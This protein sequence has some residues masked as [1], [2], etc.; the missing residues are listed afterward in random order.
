MPPIIINEAL[1]A[2]IN[3]DAFLK[4]SFYLQGRRFE[5]T[6]G[7]LDQYLK[8]LDAASIPREVRMMQDSWKNLVLYQEKLVE[9]SECVS[10]D[11]VKKNLT[12]LAD[13]IY[14]KIIQLEGQ[15]YLLL[16]GG[17]VSPLSGHAVVYQISLDADGD[18]VFSINNSGDGL[19]YHAKKSGEEKEL[20]NPV[21]TYKIPKQQKIEKRVF[22]T[23]L[24]ALLTLQVPSLHKRK[25][26]DSKDLYEQVLPKI[27][28][29]QGTVVLTESESPDYW[30]TAGQL[31]GT[32]AQHS[33]H[34]ML[35]SRHPDLDTY[36]KFI[37]GFKAH[38]LDE[39]VRF[40]KESNILNEKKWH[41]QIE[42]AIRH[43][44]KLLNLKSQKEPFDDLF[45]FD[46]KDTEKT[47]L[48]NYLLEL[49]RVAEQAVSLTSLCMPAT[50]PVDVLYYPSI[51]NHF[52]LQKVTNCTP[53]LFADS[54]GLSQRRPWHG[55]LKEISGGDDLFRAMDNL[56]QHC[57]DLESGTYDM[58]LLEQLE[59]FFLNLPLPELNDLK[60]DRP[61][62]DYYKAITDEQKAF[63]FYQKI[64][65]LQRFYFDASC[66]LFSRAVLLPR[67][68]LIKLSII[69]VTGYLNQHY[70]L[71][72]KFCFYDL[73]E[74]GFMGS[75][76]GPNKVDAV[77]LANNFPQ[78][79]KRL[80]QIK[81]LYKSHP[82]VR[83]LE[84]C[85]LSEESNTAF[86]YYNSL[87][88][89]EPVL[90]EELEKKY[91]AEEEVNKPNSHRAIQEKK[92][93]ALYYF[94][95]HYDELE[96]DLRFKPLIDKFKIQEEIEAVYRYYTD[97]DSGFFR[98][99]SSV[100]MTIKY[101]N[102]YLKVRSNFFSSYGGV[103]V[104]KSLM[105]A[106]YNQWSN[107]SAF[108]LQRDATSGLYMLKRT[109]NHTQLIPA[110]FATLDMSLKHSDET[111]AGINQHSI[112]AEDLEAR[113]LFHLR[114]DSRLQIALTLDYFNQ[115]LAKLERHELKAYLEANLFQPGLLI[116]E[117]SQEQQSI[118]FLARFDAFVEKG[119]RHFERREQMTLHSL[120]FIRLACQVNQ[121]AVRFSSEQ[122]FLERL[123]NFTERLEELIQDTKELGIKASLTRELFL[124]LITRFQCENLPD[125]KD[126]LRGLYALFYINSHSNDEEQL[127]TDS[128]FS[129]EFAKYQWKRLLA[130]QLK[131][132][133]ESLLHDG[134]LKLLPTLN[135]P[136]LSSQQSQLTGAY[137]LYHISTKTTQYSLDLEQGVVFQQNRAY[138]TLPL[139]LRNHP[140][141]QQLKLVTLTSCFVS[142]DEKIFFIENSAATM[143]FI[144]DEQG[145]HVQK[146]WDNGS[147]QNAWYQLIPLSR[148]QGKILGLPD[149][150]YQ[151][152]LVEP[153]RDILKEA[154][155][156]AWIREDKQELLLTDS[157][158]QPWYRT[159]HVD[160]RYHLED[161][162]GQRPMALA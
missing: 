26:I 7:Y 123:R 22:L 32:C 86:S 4:G 121:Y 24:E 75:I 156:L 110:S 12:S 106:K 62:L 116:K 50:P 160:S 89:L 10:S 48:S 142:Q 143:R 151:F 73:I 9:L 66:R 44:L 46:F 52:Q 113:Q 11:L 16:P 60:A 15:A 149:G 161:R 140:V 91:I 5:E 101:E 162:Q 127:D 132:I 94:T 108:A 87:L 27:S 99:R 136:I 152:A 79:D 54:Q 134:L 65:V 98:A 112:E 124:A 122:R 18:I 33:L 57:R 117:L 154:S 34:Q 153:L 19:E 96:K 14:N 77:Y 28:Y 3:N 2:H 138:R 84:D 39:Y 74:L 107:N 93:E 38:A 49:N 69:A 147:S 25:Q 20:Y 159:K 45:D 128:Q 64:N 88:E 111:R 81:T 130:D 137:P 100:H 90:K 23:W 72:K 40:L 8:K 83:G 155:I 36:Q 85:Y 53:L 92:C 133:E 55:P 103:S 158:N 41:G 146:C 51:P 141:L 125:Q 118:A 68:Y 126:L 144:K 17:W 30:F 102:G 105:K 29:L 61:L 109:D 43:Q 95:S 150:S 145:Y 47:R 58:E 31:S 63:E 78:K 21:L 114:Q 82:K 59:Q 131:N 1:F 115:K 42:K 129:L 139:A 56:L 70:T 6:I 104:G 67:T 37:Y 148:T 119:L 135:I 71:S 157:D 80:Q 35:K 13:E 120:F 97:L 76:V